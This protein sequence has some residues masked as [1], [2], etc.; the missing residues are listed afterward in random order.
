MKATSPL[1]PENMSMLV[2]IMLEIMARPTAQ[3]A[4][5]SAKPPLNICPASKNSGQAVTAK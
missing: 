3:A 2:G 5:A 1:P 4:I